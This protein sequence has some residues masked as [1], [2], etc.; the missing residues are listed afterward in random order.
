MDEEMKDKSEIS[1]NNPRNHNLRRNP[2]LLY[3]SLS[4]HLL[5]F[6]PRTVSESF[7]SGMKCNGCRGAANAPARRSIYRPFSLH[8]GTS[9]NR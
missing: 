9:R 6:D 4:V 7:L 5:H 8:P 1:I 3:D 2:C